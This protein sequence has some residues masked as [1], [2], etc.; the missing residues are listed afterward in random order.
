MELVYKKA[1]IK[2]IE[3]LTKSRVQVLIAANKLPENTNMENVK[4]KPYEYYREA[5]KDGSHTA[6][7]V[8]D[9][10]ILVGTG[11]VSYY[12]VMPTYHNQ[13]GRKAYIMNMYTKPEYR[14]KGIAKKTLDLLVKEAKSR[15]I[16]DILLEATDMGRLLYKK[17]GFVKMD[18]EMELINFDD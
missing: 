18:N 13:D 10:E 7:L 11:G 12:R 8:F 4:E 1:T 9:G 5:L 17:Y 6:Y 15:G 3:I 16:Q 2:D 14:R